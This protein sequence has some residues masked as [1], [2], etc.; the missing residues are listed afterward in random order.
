V[1]WLPSTEILRLL[2]QYI[3]SV[4]VSSVMVSC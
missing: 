4:M 2:S 1:E 3:D